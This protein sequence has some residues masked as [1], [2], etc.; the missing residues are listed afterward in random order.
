[1]L[2]PII[3][4]QTVDKASATSKSYILAN[5]LPAAYRDPDMV[6]PFGFKE[7]TYI[8]LVTMVVSL[9]YLNNRMLP[10]NKLTRYLRRMNADDATPIGNTD[11]LLQT[12]Q[13]NGYIVRVK[14]TTGDE[15]SYD[16]HIG[17]RAKVEIGE[18]GVKEF[19]TNIY[20]V[21][22]PKDLDE[23]IN[24]NIGP[25]VKVAFEAEEDP[26][27]AAKQKK[28][29]AKRTRGRQAVNDDSDDDD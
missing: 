1:M 25:E 2:I 26:E 24:R 16:Y 14:D 5:I 22:A 29:P 13:R 18:D 6:Q 15:T 11:K 27:A 20:G 3:A 7:Q 21:N 12:M 4:A 10:A 28:A 8:G 17:P 9:I 23:R 19:L